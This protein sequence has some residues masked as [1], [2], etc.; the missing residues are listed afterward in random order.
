MRSRA[1]AR[2]RSRKRSKL[3]NAAADRALALPTDVGDPQAVAALFKAVKEKFGRVDALFNNA[4]G[5]APG[6]L[7]EDLTLGEME[8]GRRCEPER[9]LPLRAGRVTAS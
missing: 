3:G 2:N 6:I 9:Q 1:A 7:F 4:G 8:I 5:N